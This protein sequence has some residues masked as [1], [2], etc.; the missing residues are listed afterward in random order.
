V[1]SHEVRRDQ[2]KEIY[3]ELFI[4]RH[5][6][7]KAHEVSN[8]VF[9]CFELDTLVNDEQQACLYYSN[10]DNLDLENTEVKK[11]IEEKVW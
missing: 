2:L 11:R 10:K 4:C 7:Y 5:C 9:Y 3:G 1:A 8:Q 6:K